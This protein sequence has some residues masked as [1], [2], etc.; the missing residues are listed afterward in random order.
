MVARAR[1]D[2][3][4]EPRALRNK[5]RA[6]PRA[7]DRPATWL[8]PRVQLEF[9]SR[10]GKARRHPAAP[11]PLPGA[12]VAVLLDVDDVEAARVLREP[13]PDVPAL[14]REDVQEPLGRRLR[15]GG[16]LVPE[17][18]LEPLRTGLHVYKSLLS[19]ALGELAIS[20]SRQAVADADV[21]LHADA[22]GVPWQGHY[23]QEPPPARP[24]PAVGDAPTEPIVCRRAKHRPAWPSSSFD[25]PTE[26]IDPTPYAARPFAERAKNAPRRA[27]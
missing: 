6:S 27:S 16:G 1:A 4:R 22:D 24:G 5:R 25:S 8:M 23:A 14:V 9:K 20:D 10:S 21:A 18:A 26:S 19:E 12:G 13:G 7:R 3:V 17:L 2:A 11:E 15:P